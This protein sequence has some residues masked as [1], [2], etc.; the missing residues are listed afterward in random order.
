VIENEAIFIDSK[1]FTDN[2]LTILADQGKY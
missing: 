1:T 2:S